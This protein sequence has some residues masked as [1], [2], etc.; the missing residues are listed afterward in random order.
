MTNG[1]YVHGISCRSKKYFK[2]IFDFSS[3]FVVEYYVV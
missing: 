1:L 2:F 3:I